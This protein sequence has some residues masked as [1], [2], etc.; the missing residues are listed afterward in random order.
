VRRLSNGDKEVIASRNRDLAKDALRVLAFA[1]KVLNEEEEK[2]KE[3]IENDL[4]FLGLQGMIDAPRR[5]VRKAVETCRRA[6]IRVVMITGDNK[7]TAQAIAKEVG[8]G[9][10][11]LEGK[12]LDRIS[13][14]QLRARIKD[15]DI[16]ARVSPMHKVGILKALQENKH[17]V[18]MTGD[19]V[20]DAPALKSADV[21]VSMGIRGTDVAKQ[22]SDMVLLDDNFATIVDAVRNGRTIFDNIRNFVRYLLTTNFAEV[23]VVFFASLFGYLPIMPVQLLWINF[24]TD[25]LPALALGIDPTRKGTMQRMPRKKA[26]GIMNRKSIYWIAAIGV[27]LAVVLLAIFFIGLKNGLATARTMVFTGFVLYEFVKL[28]VIRYQQQLSWFSN[29]WLVSATSG[30]LV[31]QLAIL[32]TP[33][34]RL[35]HVV[36][37]GVFE[38]FILLLGAGLSWIFAVLITKYIVRYDH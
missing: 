31:L 25:G 3:N 12:D 35:F 8:I 37:L 29:K 4:I 1:H 5:G 23:L 38:W 7:I 17:V 2:K 34:N 24:L 27:E 6:G 15:V 10:N 16:F 14:E 26:E 28:S 30:C 36:P 19:G 21:G 32:Y 11:I 9:S 13:S 18:A 20:N 22:T 33:L